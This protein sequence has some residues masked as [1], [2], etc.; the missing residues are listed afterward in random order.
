MASP[1]GF[2]AGVDRAIDIVEKALERFGAPVYV[3]HEIVHNQA[4]VSRL[5]SRGAIFVEELSEVPKGAAAIFSAHGVALSVYREAEDR[6]LVTIDATC[7]LVKKV[8]A[9]V[10]KHHDNRRQIIL[11]G[12]KGHPEILGTM[13]QAPVGRVL[14]V[15]TVRDVQALQG[16]DGENLAYTT[17]TTLPI[18][19][20]ADII[21]ALKQRFPGI[22]GPDRGDLCYATT[23]RQR[24]LMEVA[25][26]ADA[27]IVVGS[28]NSANSA[29][30]RDLGERMGKPSLLVDG[31][32]DLRREWFA[33]LASVGI[34]AGASAPEASVQD[35]VQWL[36]KEFPVA[37][38]E[39]HILLEE[40]IHF[41]L[42][43]ILKAPDAAPPAV[44]PVP[45]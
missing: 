27:I 12:Q 28:R 13:G 23:N 8:H 41:P 31:P 15:E 24:A 20:T 38:V 42:P 29:L 30:L 9:S 34:S 36:R 5:R 35:V 7:P 11:I 22:K 37:Q 6:G 4:V 16:L 1:R 18:D 17:Q 10:K 40:G 3:R 32:A 25:R 45:T 43:D 19:D 14:L 33:D 44:E 2:C 26:L 21:A 39:D